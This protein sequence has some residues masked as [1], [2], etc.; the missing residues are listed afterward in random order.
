MNGRYF[1]FAETHVAASA[2][3]VESEPQVFLDREEDDDAFIVISS[4]K[5]NDSLNEFSQNHQF[6]LILESFDEVVGFIDVS[7]HYLY[8]QQESIELC[9]E[10]LVLAISETLIDYNQSVGVFFYIRSVF[11]KLVVC[12]RAEIV[13]LVFLTTELQGLQLFNALHGLND[14]L[15][16]FHLA[17]QS[18]FFED[19]LHGKR[20]IPYCPLVVIQSSSIVIE[21]LKTAADGSKHV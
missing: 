3:D 16:L 21:F 12:V 5:T 8:H 2:V 14:Q 18:H 20:L 11:T 15:V 10:H 6:R 1:R 13:D 19:K 9:R 17:M 7:F 4:H